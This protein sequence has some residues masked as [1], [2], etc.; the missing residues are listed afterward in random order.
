[1]PQLQCLWFRRDSSGVALFYLLFNLISATEQ[2]A[3]TFFYI[4]NDIE[5]VDVFVNNRPPNTGD[6]LNLL[7]VA[8]VWVLWLVLYSP[9]QSPTT[10]WDG[11]SLYSTMD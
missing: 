5:P 10:L 9:T 11:N 8:L 6:W 3:I 7:Q 4:V 1:M 2:F